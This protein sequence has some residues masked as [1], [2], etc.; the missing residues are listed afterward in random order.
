MQHPEGC[1][2]SARILYT[3]TDVGSIALHFGSFRS[4]ALRAFE[5]D[6]RLGPTNIVSFEAYLSFDCRP[7]QTHRDPPMNFKQLHTDSNVFLLWEPC[8]LFHEQWENSKT[9][10]CGCP[11][12]A[13]A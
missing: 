4:L 5:L 1:A 7:R 6:R 12:E 11:E 13:L 10:N 9:D 8:Q 3:V 2:C